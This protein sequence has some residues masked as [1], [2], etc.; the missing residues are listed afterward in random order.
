MLI[1]KMTISK[2]KIALLYHK[3]NLFLK[4]VIFFTTLANFYNDIVLSLA[5][6]F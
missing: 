2:I 3:A 4:L 1:L 6:E 5:K